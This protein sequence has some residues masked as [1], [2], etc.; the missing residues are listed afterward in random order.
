MRCAIKWIEQR[1]ARMTASN[2][3]L[4]IGAETYS[5]AIADAHNYMNWLVDQFKPYLH[6]QI[7]EVGIGHGSYCRLLREHGDYIGI[8]HDA[9]S[10][11]DARLRFPGIVFARCDI[12]GAAELRSAVPGGADAVVSLNVFEHIEDDEKALGN[13]ISIIKPGGHLLVSVPAMMILYNELDRLA[14]HVRRYTTAR[15]RDILERQPV[16]IIRLDYINPVGALGWWMNSILRPKSLDSEAINRQ[17]RLFDRY[18][19]PISKALGPLS[20]SFFGQS[21]ICIARRL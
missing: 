20:R 7:L 9:K 11:A 19:I 18:A 1:P 16:E 10:V 17:I 5:S 21:V 3:R 13:V 15:L 12:L 2:D 14:G 4:K 8:D 6:G